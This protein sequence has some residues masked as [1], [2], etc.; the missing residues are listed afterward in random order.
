MVRKPVDMMAVREGR[1]RMAELV[2]RH[3]E[4]TSPEAQARLGGHLLTLD[5]ASDTIGDMTA[6]TPTRRAVNLRVDPDLMAAINAAETAIPALSRHAICL[7][8]LHIGLAALIEDPA[9]AVAQNIR[10][11]K[12]PSK[13]RG[14]RAR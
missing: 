8:A 2:K 9:L 12:P 5:I 1:R 7:A 10:G 3:P 4:L 6:P 14:K 13:K 11:R